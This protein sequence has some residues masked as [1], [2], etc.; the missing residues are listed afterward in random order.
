MQV[1]QGKRC[2]LSGPIENDASDHNWR[3]GPKKVLVDEFKI[4]L[5][6]P[7]EDPKQVWAKPLQIA[8]S[9]HDYDEI[10]RI[11]KMFVRKDLA[12]VDRADS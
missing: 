9:S 7:F 11:A 10:A 3:I 8:R 6:D 2:Y 4:D 5:F 1:L 12:M